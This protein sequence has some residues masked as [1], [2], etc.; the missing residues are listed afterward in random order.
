MGDFDY[1]KY[2]DLGF[3]WDDYLGNEV[4]EHRDLW[5]GVWTRSRVPEWATAAAPAGEW[6]VLVISEDWCGDASNT[7]PVI[8]RLAET[9]P[10]V[11]MRVVKRDEHPELMDRHLTSGS[12]SIPLAVVLRPDWSVAGQWGPRPSELQDFVLREK[13]AELRP[14][15]D[16]Y[17][18]V[19]TWYARDRGETT[20][21]EILAVFEADS[22]RRAAA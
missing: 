7:V 15:G 5:H 6:K 13:K 16:I 2:W 10:N 20:I 9:L 3:T 17:R 18:D 8:A 19:R 12:R 14:V 4:K 11:E 22:P 21:R 1:R